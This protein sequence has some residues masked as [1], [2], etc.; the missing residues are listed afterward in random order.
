MTTTTTTLLVALALSSLKIDAVQFQGPAKLQPISLQA[1][2][3]AEGNFQS[4]GKDAALTPRANGGSDT[5]KL[6]PARLEE[7]QLGRSFVASGHGLKV[8]DP[9]DSVSLPRVP[10]QLPA[11]KACARVASPDRTPTRIKVQIKLPNGGELTSASRSIWFD[12]EW[13]DVVFEFAALKVDAPGVYKV[14]FSLDGS[15]V[16]ELPLEIRSLKQAAEPSGR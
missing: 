14:V 4:A 10:A 1:I 3:K 6:A 7:A 11:F 2:P 5:I 9:M 8:L 13:A 16:A 12:G 15:A